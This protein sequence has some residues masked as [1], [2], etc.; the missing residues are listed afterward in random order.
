MVDETESKDAEIARLNELLRGTGANRYWEG[1][2]RDDQKVISSLRDELS[3]ER[4]SHSITRGLRRGAVDISDALRDEKDRIEAELDKLRT[5]VE[6]AEARQAID[7]EVIDHLRTEL[8]AAQVNW[9]DVQKLKA[10]LK[11]AMS[12]AKKESNPHPT[13]RA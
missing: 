4:E 10:E 9:Q 7:A 12:D 13:F 5:K 1:R 6:R 11:E 8:D 3:Q 2:W